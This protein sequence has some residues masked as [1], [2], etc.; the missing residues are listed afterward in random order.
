[1]ISWATVLLQLPTRRGTGHQGRTG[2]ITT[3]PR[4][5]L[6]EDAV[7]WAA[8]LA[9][10]YDMDGDDPAGLCGALN[11]LRCYGRFSAGVAER[12][13]CRERYDS[14]QRLRDLSTDLET[15]RTHVS[16]VGIQ[17]DGV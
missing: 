7:L 16:P 8:L 4:P 15:H 17:P 6:A 2:R 14:R 5:D 13:R 3:D 10:A 12:R 11:G 1:M 9:L